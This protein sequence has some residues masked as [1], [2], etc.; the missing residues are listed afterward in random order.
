MPSYF[1]LKSIEM[2]NALKFHK[3]VAFCPILTRGILPEE[4]ISI[5]HRRRN[6][7]V[8]R[9]LSVKQHGTM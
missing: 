9:W 4:I 1:V 6:R 5:F 8:K 3:R 2:Q 7:C